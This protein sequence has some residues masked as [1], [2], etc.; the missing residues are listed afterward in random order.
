[1]LDTANLTVSFISVTFV[2]R[3]QLDRLEQLGTVLR[4][5]F[6]HGVG[7]GNAY[8]RFFDGGAARNCGISG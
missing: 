4:I 2:G 1:M 5:C 3:F 8:G 7:C 6:G